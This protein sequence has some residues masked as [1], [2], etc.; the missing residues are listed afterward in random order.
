M[1]A[2]IFTPARNDA[3][4]KADKARLSIQ[5]QHQDSKTI[6]QYSYTDEDYRLVKICQRY[7]IP[8]PKGFTDKAVFVLSLNEHEGYHVQGQLLC[9]T[10]SKDIFASNTTLSRFSKMSAQKLSSIEW[11][12]FI[13]LTDQLP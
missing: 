10:R 12:A 11:T 7:G 13:G 6:V 5:F 8:Q 4:A 9:L 2:Y 1:L 3:P